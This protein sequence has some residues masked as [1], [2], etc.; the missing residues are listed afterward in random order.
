MSPIRSTIG[1]VRRYQRWYGAAAI[2]AVLLT[3]VPTVGFTDLFTGS[4]PQPAATAPTTTTV[5]APT[6]IGKLLELLPPEVR[7]EIEAYDPGAPPSE[8]QPVLPPV[9]KD[10]LSQLLDD[11]FDLLPTPQIPEVP[12]ELQPLVASL[13][14][15]ASYGCSAT[16][17]TALV[18]SA[19]TPALSDLPLHRIIPLLAPITGLCAAFPIPDVHTVCAIDEDLMIDVGG[20]VTTPPIIGLGIDQ[21]DLYEAMIASA[22]GD[23]LPR[24]A[25][26]LRSIFDC[27]IVSTRPE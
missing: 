15:F 13:A 1:H 25:P 11:V 21:I 7:E 27:E 10:E 8:D 18:L 14:P 20:L 26:Q 4:A 6:A 17:L 19:V 22:Y 16:G 9:P 2:W 3:V 12:P 23:A 24:L 5:P